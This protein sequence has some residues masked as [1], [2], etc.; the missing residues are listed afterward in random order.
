MI[1]IQANHSVDKLR[2]VNSQ[3]IGSEQIFRELQ[4]PTDDALRKVKDLQELIKSK[5]KD[6]EQNQDKQNVNTNLPLPP[7]LKLCTVINCIIQYY[8]IVEKTCNK[9]III[10]RIK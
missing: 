10:S 6:S 2:T 1:P 8:C 5:W 3:N 4:R 7:L 9:I